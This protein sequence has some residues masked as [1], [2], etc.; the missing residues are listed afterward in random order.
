MRLS[1]RGGLPSMPRPSRMR[2]RACRAAPRGR[3]GRTPPPSPAAPRPPCKAT[4]ARRPLR[5]KAPRREPSGTCRA[6]ASCNTALCPSAARAR[7][8]AF[9]EISRRARSARGRRGLCP[10]SRRGSFRAPRGGTPP[11]PPPSAN[12]Y[13]RARRA[14][15]RPRAPRPPPCRP[16]RLRASARP[17]TDK[18]CRKAL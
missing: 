12:R 18:A 3:P 9:S 2:L 16:P 13:R 14:A 8:R 6:A 4:K 1:A 17:N 15:L 10:A 7:R 11:R 5:R